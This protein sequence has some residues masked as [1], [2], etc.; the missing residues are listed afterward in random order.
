MWFESW[1][2]QSLE[3]SAQS[4]ADSQNE[5]YSGLQKNLPFVQSTLWN[6][7]LQEGGKDVKSRATPLLLNDVVQGASEKTA[8]PVKSTS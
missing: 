4:H 8:P 6:D 2:F 3:W 5:I 7:Y 1:I